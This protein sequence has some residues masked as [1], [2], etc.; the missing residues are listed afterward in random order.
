MKDIYIRGI[1]LLLILLTVRI[2]LS[3]VLS[4]LYT[5]EF[6]TFIYALFFLS[7]G[8]FLYNALPNLVLVGI[9]SC[10]TYYIRN[11]ESIKLIIS[12][13][14]IQII[15]ILIGYYFMEDF[16]ILINPKASFSDIIEKCYF[17]GYRFF[18]MYITYTIFVIIYYYNIDMPYQKVW[19]TSSNFN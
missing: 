12:I 17:S 16:R 4:T 7:V 18:T 6:F 1:K 5:M 9:L 19:N 2:I 10:C 15:V 3:S 8:N 14:S 13:L 11:N